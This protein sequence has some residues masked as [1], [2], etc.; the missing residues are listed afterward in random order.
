MNYAE[1]IAQAEKREGDLSY[2]YCDDYAKLFRLDN[3][4]RTELNSIIYNISC[5]EDEKYYKS[6][7]YY[8]IVLTF[9]Q[10]DHEDYTTDDIRTTLTFHGINN[11]K[12]KGYINE[13]IYTYIILFSL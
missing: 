11:C 2:Y 1:I 9:N 10:L 7:S 5:S 4:I 8:K 13:D 12:I 6:H 3:L